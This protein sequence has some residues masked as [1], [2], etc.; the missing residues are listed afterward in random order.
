MFC[1]PKLRLR[2]VN[3]QGPN[4]CEQSAAPR[5]RSLITVWIERLLLEDSLNEYHE[6]HI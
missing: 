3:S 4:H 6:A 2:R 5:S 1:G